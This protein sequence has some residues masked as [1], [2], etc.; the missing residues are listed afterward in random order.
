MIRSRYIITLI[1]L[2]L[3]FFVVFIG[4]LF[5][6]EYS[7]S[8]SDILNNSVTAQ[9]I[10][11]NFRL[12]KALAAIAVGISLSLSG[13]LMQ[14]LFK[15]PIAGPYILGIS[16]GA[17]LGVAVFTMGSSFFASSIFFHFSQVLG[18]WI[19]SLSMMLILLFLLRYLKN[20]S[21]L[22]ILGVMLAAL[23][24]ALISV[25][26]Y[27]SED[28]LL[29]SFVVWTMGS[30]SQVSY[31]NLII[32]GFAISFAVLLYLFNIKNINILILGTEEVKNYG[33]HKKRLQWII[34]IITSVLTAVV[35]AFCG[36]IGFIGIIVPHFAKILIK[37]SD[38]LYLLPIS[39][40]LGSIAML[41]SDIITQLPSNGIIL[42]INSVTAIMGIPF[43]LWILLKPSKNQF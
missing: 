37:T 19:G 28:Y 32:M 42:P 24:G 23:A 10:F 20:I 3:I 11:I 12:P 31:P 13:L 17:S 41:L 29:K 5:T 21:T 18:A 15:N 14:T 43:V 4:N 22:L 30:L 2:L 1:T 16:S 6:G 35:T 33:V 34:L 25:L 9:M 26:Q 40:L 7:L 39:M 36:P 8:Y 27:F 38:H